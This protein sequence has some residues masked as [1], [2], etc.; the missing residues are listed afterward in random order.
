MREF[1]ASLHD[2]RS[3][4]RTNYANIRS[5]VFSKENF[6][7]LCIFEL[8]IELIIHKRLEPR[9]IIV[10]ILLVSFEVNLADSFFTR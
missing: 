6:L 7:Y 8:E 9:K 2:C 1:N 3:P 10:C 5:V 4:P